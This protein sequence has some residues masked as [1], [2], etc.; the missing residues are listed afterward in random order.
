[1]TSRI[2]SPAGAIMVVVLIGVGIGL[3]IYYWIAS[4][5]RP[6]IWYVFTTAPTLAE[7]LSLEVDL[8][9]DEE[10]QKK[11]LRKHIAE[12]LASSKSPPAEQQEI[13][14]VYYSEVETGK[15][16]GYP[17]V[18]LQN[19]SGAPFPY[20]LAKEITDKNEIRIMVNLVDVA[21]VQRH[22]VGNMFQNLDVAELVRTEE[23]LR[24]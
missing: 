13:G 22:V 19:P 21:D 11:E 14:R 16:S 8:N 15:L 3:A 2:K 20:T 1:M 23:K 9:G 17:F 18:I 4:Q 24:R 10:T 12:M 6:G 5:E 7:P